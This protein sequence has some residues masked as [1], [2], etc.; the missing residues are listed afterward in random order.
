MLREILRTTP[1]ISFLFI[2]TLALFVF[3]SI[4]AICSKPSAF[5]AIVVDKH[6]KSKSNKTGTGFTSTNGQ[7]G[8][9]TISESEP[10]KFIIILKDNNGKILTE[11]CTPELYY[12]KAIGDKINCINYKGF[13]TNFS[14]SLKCKE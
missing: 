9:I 6:Y 13:F 5:S 4:D 12:K 1:I 14:W 7:T 8:F 3:L 10:E 2:V 11:Y